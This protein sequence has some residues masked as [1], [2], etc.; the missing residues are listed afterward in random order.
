MQIND[1]V[2]IK[3]SPYTMFEVGSTHTISYYDDRPYGIYLCDPFYEG[4]SEDTDKAN[5]SHWP[6]SADEVEIVE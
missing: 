2:R 4:M 5:N 6:F 1:K 3:S